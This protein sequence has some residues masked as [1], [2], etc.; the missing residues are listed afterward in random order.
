MRSIGLGDQTGAGPRL[1]NGQRLAQ[2]VAHEPEE[3]DPRALDPQE[4]DE[5]LDPRR[6]R[7]S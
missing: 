6:A 2:L 1:E 3:R 5:V 7:R 4:R